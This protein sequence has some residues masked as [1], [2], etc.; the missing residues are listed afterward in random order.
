MSIENKMTELFGKAASKPVEASFDETKAHFLAGTGGGQ[1]STKPKNGK[2]LT[3]KIGL[4]MITVICGFVVALF[5][6]PGESNETRLENPGVPIESETL[7]VEKNEVPPTSNNVTAAVDKGALDEQVTDLIVKADS[8]SQQEFIVPKMRTLYVPPAPRI[9]IESMEP[10]G[11]NWDDIPEL[12]EDFIRNNNKAKKKMLQVLLKLDTKHY[13]YVPSG[14]FKFQ[15]KVV[16]VQA[17]H[18]GTAEVSNGQYKTFLYDLLIQGRQEDFLKARPDGSLWKKKVKGNTEALNDL[19]FE[20]AAF[21]NYPVCNISREGAEMYCVWLS[22]EVNKV[23]KRKGDV[24]MNDVRLPVRAEWALAA[25]ESGKSML[26]PWSGSSVC[27]EDGCFLANFDAANYTGGDSK[28]TKGKPSDGALFTARTKTYHPNEY[29]L[30]NMS[31]NVAEMV[32]DSYSDSRNLVRRGETV[33]TA[34]GGWMSPVEALQIEGSDE[35]S[36]YMEGHPNIGFRVVISY[37]GRQ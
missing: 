29:G 9:D 10:S 4:I 7:L 21:S 23:I 35:Y 34:G 16:S 17:F 27:N 14:S 18:M 20:H 13:A 36:G 2:S 8:A 33:G 12:S 15:G 37:L 11:L 22:T 24:P 32:Y 28:E 31:G 1:S 26:Y 6:V 3:L 5:M 30:Y 19:Y 25:S